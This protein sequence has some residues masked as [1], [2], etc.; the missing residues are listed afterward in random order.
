MC[1]ASVILILCY[2]KNAIIRLRIYF[3][4]V[5]KFINARCLLVLDLGVV[6]GNYS[7]YRHIYCVREQMNN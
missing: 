6:L 5:W 4:P 3:R 7:F 1:V 2:V